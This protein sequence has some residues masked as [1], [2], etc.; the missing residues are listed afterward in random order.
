MNC[1]KIE[2]KF[3]H[4]KTMISAYFSGCGFVSIEF[5]PTGWQYNSQFFAEIRL[6]SIERNLA[7]C[8]PKL[9]AAAAHLRVD[10]VALHIPKI[11]IE[12]IEEFRFTLAPQSPYSSEVASCDFLLFRSL[13]RPL[14]G[15][16]FTAE[17]QGISAVRKIFDVVWL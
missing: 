17:D 2:K 6:L 16:Q 3:F 5:L 14:E 9:R 10:N 13:K 8:R 15:K 7:E 4:R 1:F 11:F 12:K